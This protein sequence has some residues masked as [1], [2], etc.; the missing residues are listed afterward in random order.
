MKRITRYM[1]IAHKEAL[2][3]EDEFR[4]G[5]VVVVGKNI[6]GKGFNQGSKTHPIQAEMYPNRV[7]TGLHAEIAA[8]RGLRP[9][10]VKN[11]E[12]FIYRLKDDGTVGAARPC[13]KCFEFIQDIGLVRVFFTS[14]NSN[15]YS[16]LGV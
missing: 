5:A 3:S 13:D 8:L 7:G 1:R 15:L 16:E 4:F 10:D 11:G 2:K 9:Y 14:G 6:V 12:M